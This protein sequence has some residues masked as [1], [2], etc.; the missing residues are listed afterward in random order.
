VASTG[1]VIIKGIFTTGLN[2]GNFTIKH[3]KVTSGTST[4]FINSFLK[5]TRIK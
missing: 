4:V 3:A 5:V 2:A 1:G